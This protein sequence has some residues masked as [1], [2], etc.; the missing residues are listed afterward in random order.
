MRSIKR[1]LRNAFYSLLT[2]KAAHKILYKRSLNKKLNINNPKDFNEK[3]QWLIINE[4]DK[5][6]ADLTDKIKVREYI[7]KKGYKDILTNIY[8]IYN[9]SE[10]INFEQLPNEFVLKTNHGSGK[11][12][13][14][15]DKNK[16]DIEMCKKK[17]DEELKQDFSKQSLEYHYAYIKPKIMCEEYLKEENRMTPLD[18]KIHCFHGKADCILLCSE[19]EKKLKYDYYDLDWNYLNYSK[20]EY[21]SS[22]NYDKPSNL[23][24]MIKIAEELSKDFSFVRVDLYNINNKI[25]FGELTFTPAA[26]M[27]DSITDEA[28]EH[29]G[30][31]IRI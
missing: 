4:Y 14:C 16:F 19:R 22:K 2:K 13:I 9:S 23:N 20:Q 12:Y 7:E 1:K 18:Y 25:Y 27:D 6:Y 29:M 10:E 21:R 11:V 3:I 15:N 26:G 31:L 8:G 30:K 5:K 17:L 24:E 28:L